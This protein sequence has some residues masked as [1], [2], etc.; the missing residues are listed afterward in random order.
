M[1][2]VRAVAVRVPVVVP[3]VVFAAQG[4]GVARKWIGPRPVFG[5]DLQLLDTP[6]VAIPGIPESR[7]W[8]S[9][10]VDE[11]TADLATPDLSGNV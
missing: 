10:L 4:D 9:T 1:A 7:Q 11:V 2:T 6:T 8:P 3:R 5:P